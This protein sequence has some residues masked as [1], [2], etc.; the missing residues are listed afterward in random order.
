MLFLETILPYLKLKKTE[1]ELGINFQ[2]NKRRGPHVSP[3][4]TRVLE[5]AQTILMASY[6]SK[7]GKKMKET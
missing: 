2:K 3:E 5:E 7:K 4:E 1:A 6:K